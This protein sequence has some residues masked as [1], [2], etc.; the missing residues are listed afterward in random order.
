M[1]TSVQAFHVK[2]AASVKMISTAT[3]ASAVVDL[4]ETGVNMLTDIC[5]LLSSND[6]ET[7]HVVI[8]VDQISWNA[9]R[10]LSEKDSLVEFLSREIW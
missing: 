8:F 3:I 10:F 5:T 4:Q 7:L 6:A 9:A 1:S 2:M